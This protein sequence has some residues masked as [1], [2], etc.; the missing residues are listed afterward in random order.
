MSARTPSGQA[1]GRPGWVPA[2]AVVLAGLVAMGVT[3]ALGLWAAGAADLPDGAFPRV[4]AATV[5]TSVGGAV[6]FSGDAG[7]LAETTAG[8]TVIP[9]SVTLVGALVIAAGFLRPLRHRA[10]AGAR[11]LGAWAAKVAVLWLLGLLGL[12]LGARQTF[13]ISLGEGAIGD[14]GDLFGLTPEVGFATDVPLSL[15]F[16]L[17]WLAGVL[18][19]T[20]LVSRG[21]PLRGRLLRLRQPAQ[22]AAYAMVALLL[23]YV[24]LGLIIGLVAAG[25]RGHPAETFATLLLGLPNLAWLGLTLGLGATWEGRVEGPFSLPMPHV[26]DQVLR[27]EDVQALNVGTLSEHDGRVWWLVVAAAVLVLAAAFLTAARSPAGVPLWQHAVRMAVALALTVLM[28]CLVGRVSA[29]Y[30][31]S[32][33]GIGDLGG[34]LAGELFLRPRVWGALGLALLW[35][36][37]TGVLGA[38]L[39]R[40][41][42]RRDPTPRPGPGNRA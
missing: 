30:G 16:G 39:A 35:G 23:V 38:L 4:V 32:V 1:L 33:L 27:S 24:L 21:T 6:E 37:V 10:P 3:A 8:L 25:T 9:L 34:D 42:R 17:L 2:V 12:A 36:L 13:R 15:F 41:V 5:V 20:V 14:I 26:L 31:L 18:V 19:L 29:S 7:G 22:Q 28:I 11:E 40:A